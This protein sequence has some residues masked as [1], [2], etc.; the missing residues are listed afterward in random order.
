[1]EVMVK[2]F[3][4]RF[5]DK[6]TVY[7]LPIPKGGEERALI[8]IQHTFPKWSKNYFG[9]THLCHE[10]EENRIAQ[11]K[12]VASIATTKGYSGSYTR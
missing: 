5:P 2:A 12:Q 4:S 1:M 8:T 7:K 6:P 9:G 10:F 3:L 11:A